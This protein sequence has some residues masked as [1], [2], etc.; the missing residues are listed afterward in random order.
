MSLPESV[1]HTCL[2]DPSQNQLDCDVC[3]LEF[4]AQ[5]DTDFEPLSIDS[6]SDSGIESKDE[7]FRRESK[8]DEVETLYNKAISTLEAMSEESRQDVIFSYEA[9]PED[10]PH[11]ADH[12]A[13]HSITPSGYD[14]DTST[15]VLE[16]P[17]RSSL[18]DRRGI[19]I[20]RL[21]LS[22]LS[23]GLREED[24]LSPSVFTSDFWG[25]DISDD[26]SDDSFDSDLCEQGSPGFVHISSKL[27]VELDCSPATPP[28]LLSRS[29]VQCPPAP[30]RVPATEEYFRA[31]R[32]R[33]ASPNA[34]RVRRRLL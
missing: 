26:V 34:R 11:S 12:S 13:G 31:R 5:E 14:S 3:Y 17:P 1:S 16:S 32:T 18:Y 15:V 4:L 28:R 9:V 21:N 8:E 19:Q 33:S 25:S 10:I 27:S 22:E 6:A 7:L 24:L 29:L 2:L 30:L 20:S 23:L